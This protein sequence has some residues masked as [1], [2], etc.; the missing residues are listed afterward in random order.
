MT[1]VTLRERLAEL[2]PE[3]VAIGPGG[4]PTGDPALARRGGALLPFGGYKGFGLALMI[5][6]LGA[7]GLLAES[8]SEHESD[9][10]YLFI[11]FRPDLVGSADVFKRRVT[12]LI[13]L[14]KATP[15]QLGVDDIRIPSERAFRSRERALR[16]GLEIDRVR[17]AR[18]P[19]CAAKLIAKAAVELLR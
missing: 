11:A 7:L 19:G 1:E 18:R 13:Q 10:G 8:G 14:I 17:C 3:G 15:R 12:Q 16:D 4:E 9:Y 6:A 2:L 5:Q